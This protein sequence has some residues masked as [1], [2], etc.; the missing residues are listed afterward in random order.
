VSWSIEQDFT[1]SPAFFAGFLMASHIF[2]GVCL[3]KIQSAIE[4]KNGARLNIR[5][6]IDRG[7]PGQWNRF[8]GLKSQHKP[9]QLG[10]LAG[11]KKGKEN[12]EF[13]SGDRLTSSLWSPSAPTR[14]TPC[15]EQ[16]VDS[17]K[18][19]RS[20][21]T[22][23][24]PQLPIFTLEEQPTKDSM[25]SWKSPD[26]KTA[27]VK[28]A[29]KKAGHRKPSNAVAHGDPRA[30]PTKPPLVTPPKFASKPEVLQGTG[31]PERN[32]FN[33]E[34]LFFPDDSLVDVLGKKSHPSPF[35]RNDESEFMRLGGS[36]SLLNS[37]RESTVNYTEGGTKLLANVTT[38]PQS[39]GG[40]KIDSPRPLL[41]DDND[42]GCELPSAKNVIPPSE[43][44]TLSTKSDAMSPLIDTLLS[45]SDNLSPKI[46]HL[47]KN[48]EILS[49]DSNG[50][51]LKA[52][53]LSPKND[54][55]CTELDNLSLQNSGL[56]SEVD[57]L[58]SF[59]Y[60]S[61]SDAEREK[62]AWHR[63]FHA[64]EDMTESWEDT[65]RDGAREGVDI[66]DWIDENEEISYEPGPMEMLE[67]QSRP[68]FREPRSDRLSRKERP[69]YSMEVRSDEEESD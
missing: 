68:A 28:D 51:S 17:G 46:D 21:N 12:R 61:E 48:K 1:D 15:R 60:D 50:M 37:P 54:K 62:A 31:Q 19:E 25:I 56:S 23:V 30:C 16:V 39:A 13:E 63:N 45:Q 33:D 69:N 8:Q 11:M 53:K 64:D 3:D 36:I 2:G 5:D 49:P 4:Q 32:T 57:D 40:N 27:N 22:Q 65:A 43:S 6:F 34:I 42:S 66:Q 9:T 58:H 26:Q 47:P 35:H 14:R 44:V 24:Q 52:D 41:I 29:S 38:T 10:L 7:N 59:F 20:N 67:L 18:R 55:L